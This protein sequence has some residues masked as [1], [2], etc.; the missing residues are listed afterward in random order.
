MWLMNQRAL[1]APV[2]G[3]PYLSTEREF[4][5]VGLERRRIILKDAMRYLVGKHGVKVIRGD[6]V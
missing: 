3:I 2:R 1:I 4:G 5:T 6:H